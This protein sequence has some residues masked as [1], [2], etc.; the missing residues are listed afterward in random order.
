MQLLVQLFNTVNAWTVQ[1]LKTSC[2]AAAV[3][4]GYVGVRYG[5][6]SV[7]MAAFC[8]F[9]H[10]GAFVAYCGAFH[11]AYRLGDL[12]K[13]VRRE[14]FVACGRSTTERYSD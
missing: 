12:Q 4:H 14:L 10:F 5:R 1:G 3:L 7:L 9:V 2:M 8:A 6:K 13:V 11:R